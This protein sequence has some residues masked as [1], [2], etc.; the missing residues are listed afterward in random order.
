MTREEMVSLAGEVEKSPKLPILKIIDLPQ[1][2]LAA[3]KLLYKIKPLLLN[4]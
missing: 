1:S 3:Y 2:K 4:I